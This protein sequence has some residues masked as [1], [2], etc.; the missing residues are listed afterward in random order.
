M[1][2]LDRAKLQ[3]R[4]EAAHAAIQRRLEEQASGRDGIAAEGQCAIAEAVHNLRQLQRVD[5]HVIRS[6]GQ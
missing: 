6:R 4:I 2:E 3:K 5:F 1:L